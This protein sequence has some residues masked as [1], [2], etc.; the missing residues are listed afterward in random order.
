MEFIEK[1]DFSEFTDPQPG[2][3]KIGQIAK[4]D[5]K[6]DAKAAVLFSCFDGDVAANWG[7]PGAAKAINA[8]LKGYGNLYAHQ[9]STVGALKQLQNN[10]IFAGKVESADLQQAVDSLA[11]NKRETYANI[12]LSRLTAIHRERLTVSLT[13]LLQK[14]PT[15]VLIGIPAQ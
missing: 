5:L 3:I 13:H 1:I 8:Y 12:K 2:G 15:V 7:I 10:M 9:E 4:V 11:K 6:T 14:L